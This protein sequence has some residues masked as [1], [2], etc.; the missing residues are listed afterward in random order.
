MEE[1]HVSAN[2]EESKR[3][4]SLFIDYLTNLERCTD[5]RK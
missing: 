5:E 4:V 3:Y 2:P 1:H